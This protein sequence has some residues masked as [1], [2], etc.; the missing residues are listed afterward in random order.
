[1]ANKKLPYNWKRVKAGDIISFKYKKESTGKVRVNSILVLNPIMDVK[2]KD[3][4][5]KRHLIGIKLEESN[6]VKLLLNS[7]RIR[8]LEKIGDFIKIDDKNNLY[9]LSIKD[10]FVINDRK[11]I[12]KQA[13]DIISKNLSINGKYR[14]YDYDKA[15]KSSVYL[16]PIRARMKD[17][18]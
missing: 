6:K 17:E 15:I 11:G 18:D 8:L 9:K 16:E 5:S 13:W 1:M 3:G 4:T 10:T 7:Q 12:K 14:T 2:L